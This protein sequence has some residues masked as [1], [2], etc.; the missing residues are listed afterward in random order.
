M[1]RRD[2]LGRDGSGTSCKQGLLH[3]E[4]EISI[5]E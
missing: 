1:E 3:F 4:G 5:T 2:A